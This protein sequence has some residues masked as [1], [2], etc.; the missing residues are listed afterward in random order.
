MQLLLMI[1]KYMYGGVHN[2]QALGL[3]FQQ[4]A[5]GGR[6]MRSAGTGLLVFPPS[7]LLG[8]RKSPLY[9]GISLWNKLPK[10]CRLANSKDAFREKA[11]PILIGFF[12]EQQRAR[13]LLYYSATVSITL[14]LLP[15]IAIAI[16][17]A[18]ATVIT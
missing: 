2:N 17:I 12:L 14:T 8:Y 4:P 3:E 7:K 13:G 1:Y 18:T 9:R 5:E 10:E 11:K 15:A 6:M 16:V